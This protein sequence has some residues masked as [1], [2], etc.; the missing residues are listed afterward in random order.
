MEKYLKLGVC[1][2]DEYDIPI[3]TQVINA[4]WTEDIETELKEKFNVEFEKELATI[5]VSEL[6]NKITEE[7]IYKLISGLK[8]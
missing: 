4:N 7:S 5:L 1:V 2:L 6:K 3:R 8:T